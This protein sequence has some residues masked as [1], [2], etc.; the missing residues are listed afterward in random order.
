M[1]AFSLHAIIVSRGLA[2]LL[3]EC[4]GS[5]DR[6]MELI[7]GRGWTTGVT[8]VDNASAPSLRGQLD[9][10]P[11]HDILRFDTHHSF[12]AACNAAAQAYPADLY[13]FLNNDVLLHKLALHHMAA[14]FEADRRTAVCGTRMVFPDDTIQHA[15]VVF[16]PGEKGPYHDHRKEASLLIP[17]ITRDCQAVTGACMLVEGDIFRR[18]NGFDEAFPFGLEDVDFCLRVRQAGHRIV[19]CQETDSLH[20]ESMTPGRVELDIPSR[21][22]FMERWK[23]RYTVDG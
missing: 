13:L 20:F 16:G 4:L 5:L 3:R 15:G 11:A 7:R 18:L 14:V 10:A 1:K 9:D 2:A 21:R 17:R 22:L 6:A 23:D 8:V 19:C 12:A